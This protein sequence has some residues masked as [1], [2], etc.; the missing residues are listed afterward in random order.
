[1]FKT[2]FSSLSLTIVTEKNQQNKLLQAITGLFIKKYKVLHNHF[3]LSQIEMLTIKIILNIIR[4][5]K[6]TITNKMELQAFFTC[7]KKDLHCV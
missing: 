3:C 2:H 4:T 6:G 5:I 7:F 1:M